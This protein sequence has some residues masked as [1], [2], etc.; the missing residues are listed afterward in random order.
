MGFH[1]KY[2][3]CNELGAVEILWNDLNNWKIDM[4]F[5]MSGSLKT[6]AR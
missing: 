2:V 3:L 1:Y 6:T 5:E 4:G